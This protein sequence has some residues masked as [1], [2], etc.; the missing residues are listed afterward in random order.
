MQSETFQILLAGRNCS[1]RGVRIKALGPMG[2]DEAARVT[3]RSLDK[4]ATGV[5]YAHELQLEQLKRS[6]VAVTRTTGIK[7]MDELLKLPEKDWAKLNVQML[8]TDQELSY[9]ALFTGKDALTLRMVMSQLY[10]TTQKDV[11][12]VMGG[13]LPVSAG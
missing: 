5:E 10:D 7:S 13:A 6:L 2:L 8:E 9:D 1:G 3:A 12:A 4:E 11:D